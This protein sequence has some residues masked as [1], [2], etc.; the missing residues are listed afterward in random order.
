MSKIKYHQV[1]DL[2]LNH[3]IDL[4]KDFVIFHDTISTYKITLIF[5]PETN[6]IKE[7]NVQDLFST[8]KIIIYLD[9]D[10]IETFN[11]LKIK[12]EKFKSLKE[13]L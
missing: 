2:F 7:P 1:A 12:F 5:D 11:E 6:K 13:F 10:S 3:S 9:N 4:V 8:N